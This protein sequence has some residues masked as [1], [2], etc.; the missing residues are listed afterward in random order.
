MKLIKY[1]LHYLFCIT[2]LLSVNSHAQ[3][4]VVGAEQWDVYKPLLKNKKVGLVVN[5]TSLVNGQHLVDFL[6]SKNVKV[7]AIFAPEHGFRGNHDAG[8]VVDNNIDTKTNLPII[9]I[10]GKNKKPSQD[11]LTDLDVILFDIQDVGLRFYTYLSS[12]HYMMEAS[13]DA[14]IK[15]IVLDRPN[16]NIAFVDGPILEEEFRSF[17]GMHP[18]PILHGM[19]LAELALMIQGEGWLNTENTLNLN[20]ITVKNYTRDKRYSLPIKPS[21]NLPNDQAIRLYPSLTFF[22]STYVSLGRGTVYPFQVL[23]HDKYFIGNFNF[24]PVSMPGSALNPKLMDKELTGQDLRNVDIKGLDL[25]LLIQWYQQFKQ[26][27]AEFFKSPSFMDKLSGTDKIR[28]M[29]L[30]GNSEEQIVETWKEDLIEFKRQRKQYLL[31]K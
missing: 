26:H 8:A 1:A 6:L 10:Y 9:S 15:F 21:P 30:A 12:M 11:V 24:T 13:A 22:E 20:V 19:T 31:Y 23:G 2:L 14:D 7:K 28:K 29:I 18:I 25:S 5:Q 16:P 3:S 4:I 17:V 27:D